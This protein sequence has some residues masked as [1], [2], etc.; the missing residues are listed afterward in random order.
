MKNWYLLGLILS[1]RK[2]LLS[3]FLW[4]WNFLEVLLLDDHVIIDIVSVELEKQSYCDLKVANKTEHYVAFKVILHNITNLICFL[5]D[6]VFLWVFLPPN[7]LYSFVFLL[8]QIRWKQ[9]L[10]RSISLDPTLVSYSHGTHASLEVA[11]ILYNSFSYWQFKN[12]NMEVIK[13]F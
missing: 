3:V 9:L 7:W 11:V 1:V 12:L 10:R 2:E 4:T 8:H 13:I 6:Q 5:C